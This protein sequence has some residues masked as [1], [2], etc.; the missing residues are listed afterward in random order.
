MIPP[1]EQTRRDQILRPYIAGRDFDLDPEHE[2][3]RHLVVHSHALLSA[4]PLL[5]GLEWR[6][7]NG[8]PGDLVFGDGA[9][10]FAVVEVKH[11]GDRDR[12]KRRGDVERQALWF[13]QAW[14]QLH[15]DAVVTALVY[16]CDE[17]NADRPPRA[18][19][20]RSA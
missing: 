10:R 16:T 19:G 15:P 20:Q 4:W 8:S 12:T 18:P 17:R 11:L 6:A 1:A 5:V 7:P 3:R 2:L 14:Q 9:G 13:A